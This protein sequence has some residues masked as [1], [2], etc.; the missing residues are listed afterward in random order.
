M[1]RINLWT[2]PLPG[3]RERREDIEPN[4]QFELEQYAQKTG[5]RITFGKE[6]R[7]KFLEFALSADGK[8]KGNFRDLNAAVARMAAL[9]LGG[10]RISGEVV[11]EA[12]SAATEELVVAVLGADWGGAG[13]RGAKQRCLRIAVL[14]YFDAGHS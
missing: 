5:R 8:W 1:A 2:F 10:G 4:L 12:K 9:S 6:A 13:V 11:A 3:L 14:P 7:A